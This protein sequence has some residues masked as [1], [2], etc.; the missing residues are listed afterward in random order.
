MWTWSCAGYDDNGRAP[1]V[2][3]RETLPDRLARGAPTVRAQKRVIAA[4]LSHLS[5]EDEA[6]PG[7]FDR[8]SRVS[9]RIAR[10]ASNGVGR[11]GRQDPPHYGTNNSA[12]PPE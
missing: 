6:G 11:V 4:P 8:G 10:L 3:M 9:G 7:E 2:R 1:A 12:I 5:R